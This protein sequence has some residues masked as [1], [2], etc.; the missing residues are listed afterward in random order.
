MNIEE[1]AFKDRITLA[2]LNELVLLDIIE[3]LQLDRKQWINQFTQTHNESVEIQKENE[4]LTER[5]EYLE[6]SNNRREDIIIEQ[7]QEISDLEDNWNELKEYL[8]NVDVVV[9]YSE[10]YDGH[11]INYD[12]LIDK[13][14]ELQQE[15]KKI[16]GSIQTYDIL[17]KANVEENKQLKNNWNELRK[18]IYDGHYL[19]VPEIAKNSTY[20]IILDKMEELERGVSD[21]ED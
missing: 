4:Q 21:V 7:R 15:N 20:Q 10:N 2:Q 9:D 13:M 19:Y 6:R 18:W 1:L 12:V 5:M 14:Q 11:F 17:L 16:N 3:F 8:H